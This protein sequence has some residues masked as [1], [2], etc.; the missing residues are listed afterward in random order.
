MLDTKRGRQYTFDNFD[1]TKANRKAFETAKKFAENIVSKP[2]TVFGRTATGKTHL[3]YAVKNA[4][5]QNSSELKV[6]LTTTA[7]MQ[8]LLTD[9]LRNCGTAEQFHEKYL[10]ADVLLV[11]DI[12]EPAGKEVTQNEL[13]LLFNSFYESGKRF[14]MTS[15]QKKR[16]MEL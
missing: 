11:D 8:S 1:V 12:Q 14:M 3:L 15:S 7:E 2:L 4:I 6:I 16:I 13:I 5:E 10:Q 9:I